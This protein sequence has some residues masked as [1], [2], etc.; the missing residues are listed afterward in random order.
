MYGPWRPYLYGYIQPLRK[1]KEKEQML[2]LYRYNLEGASLSSVCRTV[3]RTYIYGPEG[4]KGGWEMLILDVN[5]L[6][7]K[8]GTF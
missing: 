4:S 7:Y 3:A 1:R 5:L 2:F 6:R 8:L